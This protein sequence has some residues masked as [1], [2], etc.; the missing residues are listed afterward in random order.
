MEL[1]PSSI[2]SLKFCPRRWTIKYKLNLDRPKRLDAKML[3]GSMYHAGT[4]AID[5][6]TDV[7]CESD[8]IIDEAHRTRLSPTYI[9][10]DSPLVDQI[11][12][13]V[14]SLMPKYRTFMKPHGLVVTAVDHY[15][16]WQTIHIERE[17]KVK[18]YRDHVLVVIPDK[19]IRDLNTGELWV[20]ERKTTS[21]DDAQW[22]RKWRLNFQTTAQV[23]AV[24]HELKAPVAGVLIEQ[25]VITRKRSKSHD[26]P[27]PQPIH[28]VTFNPHRPV[29]KTPHLKAEAA[30]YMESAVKELNWRRTYHRG[31]DPN[32]NNCE[33]CDMQDVCTG[34]QQLDDVAVMRD[35]TR[36]RSLS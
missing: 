20:V 25:V 27:L 3:L 34:Q 7:I 29:P 17:L 36:K 11:K 33:R 22:D 23:I 32:Y 18:L 21:R 9:A 19:V 5:R 13:E 24:E 4:A 31:W 10:H 8:A 28:R 1:S 2:S 35:L 30:T 16:P 6:G 15:E 26:G 14:I 12:H